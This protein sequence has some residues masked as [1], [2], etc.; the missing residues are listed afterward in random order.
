VIP[1]T[2][3]RKSGAFSPED[4]PCAVNW[5]LFE[6]VQRM[7]RKSGFETEIFVLHDHFDQPKPL[8][9][10]RYWDAFDVELPNGTS[11]ELHAFEQ[12]GRGILPIYYWVGNS[13]QLVALISGI[14]G[15]ILAKGGD[16]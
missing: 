6:A 10:I 5:G 7:P 15:Y 4:K 11:M 14:E 8:Q 2:E 12:T 16:Q 9:Q 3:L 13:G 1:E